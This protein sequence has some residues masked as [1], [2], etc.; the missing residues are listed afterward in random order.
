MDW[1]LEVFSTLA[2]TQ[3]FIKEAAQTGQDEGLAV[4]ALQQTAGRGRQGRTWESSAG[5]LFLS[6]LLRPQCAPQN[7]G[8][9]ALLAGLALA[10]TVQSL[11]SVCPVVKWPNDVLI[12][13]RKC[14]GILVETGGVREGRV[15]WAALGIGLNVAAAPLETA[16]CLDQ[17]GNR[18]RLEVVRDSAL[19]ALRRAYALWRNQGF[20]PVLSLLQHFLPLAGSPIRAHDGQFYHEG[21]FAGLDA[22]GKLLLRF[23]DGTLKTVSAGEIFI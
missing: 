20:S 12:D 7:I 21:G 2:S 8:Q 11:I 4:Q 13:G 17:Y 19:E 3:D 23:A 5:N 10:Q 22:E 9:I 16:T 15:E 14:A 1:R 18:A 6:V